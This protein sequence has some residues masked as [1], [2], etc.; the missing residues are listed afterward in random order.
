MTS[1]TRAGLIVVGLGIF[2]VFVWQP[3]MVQRRD[4]QRSSCAARSGAD[5]LRTQLCLENEYS[6]PEDVAAE[7]AEG[8]VQ[9]PHSV[10]A[11]DALGAAYRDL[12]VTG[13][14]KARHERNAELG[15]IARAGH[16]V[17]SWWWWIE[18][19]EGL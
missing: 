4:R 6:W 13:Y 11:S 5:A 19:Y 9:A 17:R 14:V 18:G 1:R 7:V 10:E 3:R 16:Y 15:P 8:L 12:A 2:V